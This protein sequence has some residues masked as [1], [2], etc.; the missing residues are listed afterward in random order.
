MIDGFRPFLLRAAGAAQESLRRRARAGPYAPGRHAPAAADGG[1]PGGA[2]GQPHH[3]QHQ[4][5]Q[6]G[7][8]VPGACGADPR[9]YQGNGGFRLQP[10]ASAARPAAHQRQPGVRT[11]AHF[12]I[13]LGVCAEVS[14][15]RT[16]SAGQR[17]AGGPDREPYRPGHTLRRAAGPPPGGAAPAEQ[18]AIP[19]RVSEV[20]EAA[21]R[22][23]DRGGSGK[24]SLHHP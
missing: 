12:F 15:Y 22:A 3:A 6:R 4:P 9:R 18:P 21:W 16:G 2:P 10:A 13:G 14:R 1:A 11:Q 5:D 17:Q 20:P 7:R 8:A 24:S 19:V 23:C